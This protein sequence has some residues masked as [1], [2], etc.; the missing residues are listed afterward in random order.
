MKPEAGTFW[1]R[2]DGYDSQSPRSVK[3]LSEKIKEH[4]LEKY[5]SK[6]L[7]KRSPYAMKFE[8][9]SQEATERQERCARGKAWNLASKASV[10]WS[11]RETS[12]LCRIG[13]HEDIEESDDGDDGQRRR[14]NK[15]RSHGKDQRIGVIRDSDAS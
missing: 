1:D 9:R 15:R 12:Q 8:E 7:I 14:A 5:K 11:P 13:D 2:F 3:Q 6:V 4:R 10:Q